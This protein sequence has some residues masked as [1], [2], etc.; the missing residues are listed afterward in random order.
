MFFDAG[1]NLTVA[2]LNTAGGSLFLVATS[3]GA[4]ALTAHAVHTTGGAGA[5]GSVVFTAD[6][7]SLAASVDAGSARVTVQ[8]YNNATAIA[9]GDASSGGFLGLTDAQLS[10]I[11]AGALQIGNSIQSGGITVNAPI[12]SHSGY[13]TLSLRTLGSISNAVST[14]TSL[15]A[16]QRIAAG[17]Q[18]HWRRRRP[19]RQCCEAGVLQW[20]RRRQ[21]CLSRFADDRCR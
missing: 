3:Q 2:G 8:P 12:A 11:T 5:A 17:R 1:A 13:D 16:D 10:Q 15:S 4:G 21:H 19:D 9:L 7:L 20:P 6:S 14:G 18:W